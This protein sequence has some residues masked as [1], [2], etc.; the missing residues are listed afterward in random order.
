MITNLEQNK[1]NAQAFYVLMF[2]HCRPRE[3]VERFVGDEY[4]RRRT[5][6][7]RRDLVQQIPMSTPTNVSWSFLRDFSKCFA[8]CRLRAVADVFCNGCHGSIR[9]P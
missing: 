5:S 7:G 3:V 9:S 6:M 4:M 1:E 8:K 2:N